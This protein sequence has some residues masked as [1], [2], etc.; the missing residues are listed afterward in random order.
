MDQRD[1]FEG[2]VNV[3]TPTRN[4]L[5][6][7]KGPGVLKEVRWLK[8]QA[9]GAATISISIIVNDTVRYNCILNPANTN[10]YNEGAYFRLPLGEGIRFRKCCYVNFS[11]GWFKPA[12]LSGTGR[13]DNMLVL[14]DKSSL[15]D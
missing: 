6:S 15:G 12:G 5:F 1:F 11:V 10:L 2:T 3:G 9:T 8:S 7:R 4:Y 14:W 13:F